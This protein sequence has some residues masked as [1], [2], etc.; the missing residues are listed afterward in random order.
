M[1]A[2]R[3]D[4]TKHQGNEIKTSL[5]FPVLPKCL[6]K[7]KMRD[8]MQCWYGF[9]K[10]DTLTLYIVDLCDLLQISFQEIN[11]AVLIKVKNTHAF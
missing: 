1:Y 4:L 7:I 2:E 5:R 9:G 3:L 10:I 8:N 6:A 11:P